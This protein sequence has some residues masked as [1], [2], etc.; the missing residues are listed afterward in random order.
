MAIG[1]PD[2][3]EA[4]SARIGKVEASLSRFLLD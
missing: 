2:A 1:E 3:E 4:E